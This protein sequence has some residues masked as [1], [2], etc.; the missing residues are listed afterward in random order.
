MTLSTVASGFT[1]QTA[2]LVSPSPITQSPLSLLFLCHE[3]TDAA[4]SRSRAER[5]IFDSL[6][7]RATS[8]PSHLFYSV[9]IPGSGFVVLD[10]QVFLRTGKENPET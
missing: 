4:V 5:N 1:S 3:H 6:I 10:I 2:T 9:K 8:A 7:Q